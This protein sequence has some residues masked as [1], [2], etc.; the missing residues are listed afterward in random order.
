VNNK[1]IPVLI[2]VPH[3]G[4][5]IPE[6]FRNRLLL[7]AEDIVQ[8][9]DTWTQ[10]V[11]DFEGKVESF[12]VMQAARIVV[13]ANRDPT[14]RPPENSDGV[15]KTVTVNGKKVWDRDLTEDETDSLIH[16]Y[17]EPFHRRLLEAV[18]RPEVKFAIDCHSMLDT[19]PARGKPEWEKRP[20]FCI[21]NRGTAGGES[22]EEVVTAPP[23]LM[24]KLQILLEEV[25]ADQP[26]DGLPLV[27][28]N[29]PFRGGF[30]TRSLGARSDIPWIQLEI[31]RRLY[32]PK[33]AGIQPDE[34]D[35]SRMQLFRDRFYEV[36]TRLAAEDTMAPEDEKS[37]S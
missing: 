25:F 16:E 2:S 17:W 9:S 5:V 35:L 12:E 23:Y 15:V 36:F 3:G 29:E 4:T 14:D 13:D 19:G 31:N 33:H 6:R 27:M 26:A 37:I 8:D 30:I 21:S 10:Y 28:I 24:R 20:A 11:Y 7:T 1:K 18:S 22:G 32:L 34:E